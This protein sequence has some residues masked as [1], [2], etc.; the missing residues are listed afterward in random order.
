MSI[1]LWPVYG[2]SSSAE[3]NLACITRMAAQELGPHQVPTWSVQPIAR[4]LRKARMGEDGS[5]ERTPPQREA[6]RPA[7]LWVE[8]Y[9]ARR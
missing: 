5:V 8:T 7:F 9:A 4:C 2:R 3:T 6:L 1:P